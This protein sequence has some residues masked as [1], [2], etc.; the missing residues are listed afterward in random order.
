MSAT[1]NT[2]VQ[3]TAQTDDLVRQFMLRNYVVKGSTK[4]KKRVSKAATAARAAALKAWM[5]KEAV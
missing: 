5:D 1:L 3:R 4:G 2:K